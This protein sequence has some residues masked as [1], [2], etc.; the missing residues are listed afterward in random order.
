MIHYF[1]A[2]IRNFAEILLPLPDNTVEEMKIVLVSVGAV[3]DPDLGPLL[4]RYTSRLPHYMPFEHVTVADVKTSRATTA[5][6]QKERE[7]DAI[8]SR[9]AP[10]DCL[11]LFDERGR[12]MT[13][14]E[15]AAFIDRKAA[16]LA[17]NLV[18]VIGGPYGFSRAVYDRADS[19]LAL[20][21][22]TLTHEWAVALAAEQLYRAQTILRGEPYHH[23]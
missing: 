21:R 2:K 18:F 14:R 1:A 4:A 22:L 11:V 17:R 6:M 13:S 19:L 7:G 12:E 16:T 8:L 20:S 10:G 9:V 3:R 23:D 5:E 15:L